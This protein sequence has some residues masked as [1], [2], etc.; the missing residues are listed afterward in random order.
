MAPTAVPIALGVLLPWSG[1]PLVKNMG[2]YDV[3]HLL[4]NAAR[5]YQTCTNETFSLD[6]MISRQQ[7]P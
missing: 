3:E 6:V 2:A 5:S 7:N 4:V 1:E